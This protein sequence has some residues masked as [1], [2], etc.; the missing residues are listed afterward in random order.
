MTPE[1]LRK[2]VMDH[3]DDE[4]AARKILVGMKLETDAETIFQKEYSGDSISDLGR[5]IHECFD[6][7]FNDKAGVLD[8]DEHGFI[9]G[10]ISVYVSYKR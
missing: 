9:N 6:P 10:T 2:L 5:D 7:S 8:S 3:V 1:E 4:V